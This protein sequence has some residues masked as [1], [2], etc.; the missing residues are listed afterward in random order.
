MAGVGDRVD[1]R[2]SRRPDVGR[3]L[4]A[5]CCALAA[6]HPTPPAAHGASAGVRAP[7]GVPATSTG[8]AY[9]RWSLWLGR[10]GLPQAAAQTPFERADLFAA[11]LLTGEQAAWTIVEQYARERF[12]GRAADEPAVQE[13]G[14]A[15]QP[16]LWW[17]W[18][19]ARLAPLR[20]PARRGAIRRR[21]PPA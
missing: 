6:S 2:G 12:G 3:S 17:A 11:A 7:A 14:H 20:D 4:L 19:Q 5:G 16:R 15:L 21:S 8:Q 10:L 1:H 9:L 13:A 18:L